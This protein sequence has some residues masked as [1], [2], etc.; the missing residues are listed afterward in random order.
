MSDD[1]VAGLTPDDVTDEE[2]W[3]ADGLGFS[4]TQCG[5]C[6]TGPPGA[7]WFD[8]DEGRAMA[9]VVGLDEREF[10]R[11]YAHR[12]GRRWSLN[13]RRHRADDGGTLHDCIFLDR[14][15]AGGATCS[16]YGARP[17]QCRTWPFWPEMLRSPEAWESSRDA[18]PCPGMGRGQTVPLVRIRVIRDEQAAAD[19]RIAEGHPG[20]ARRG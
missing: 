14:S 8:E 13:E 19:A 7:V 11:Q 1:P 15:K 20:P 16:I 3:Y 4:C 18:T 10:Y 17:T 6:C 12:V 9:E 5:N 2:A